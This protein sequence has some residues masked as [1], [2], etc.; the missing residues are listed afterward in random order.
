MMDSLRDAAKSWVAKLLIGLLAVSFGVWGIADVF[1][2]YNQG[3]L[4][5]VG[6]VD[7]TP[8]AYNIA[9][10]RYLQNMQRQTGQT[11]TPDEARKFGID[12]A[13]LDNLIQT[14]AIDD[15]ARGLKLA[16]S[17]AL[18]AKDTASNP[19]FQDSSGKF[20]PAEFRRR[21][22]QNGL[23]EAMFL[24]SE[25]EGRLREAVTG[26]VDGGFTVPKT[27]VEALYRH[28]NEQRDVRYFTVTTADSEVAIP[29]EAEIKK[30]YDTNPPSFTAPEY[31]SIAIMKVEPADITAKVS[32]TE[33]ELKQ[34]Y[35]KY[36]ADYA[37]PERRTILQL[38]FPTLDDANKAKG[39]LAAGA[40]FIA[41]AKERGFTEA[42]VTFADKSRADFIDQ[43]IAD[44]AFKLTEG[45]LS[46]P[47]KGGLSTAL[48]KVVKIVPGHQ[49]T[50]DEVR[51]KLT[52]R[53]K[54]ER[55]SEEIDSLY[56]A[57]EDARGA[58]TKFE[59]I[60]E[61]SGIPFQL[62]TGIDANGKDKDGKDIPL[63]HKAEVL[64]AAFASDVGVD[65]DAVSL[66]HGYVWYDV[67]EV[68]P[69]AVKPFEQVKD[70]AKAQAIAAKVRERA[71]SKA[72]ALVASARSGASLEDLARDA[73]SEIKTA[74]GLKRNESGDSFDPQAVAAIFAVPENGFASA[75]DADGRTAKV[76][77]SQAVLMA[78][79]DAASPDAK[80][81]A[82]KMQSAAAT[83]LLTAYLGDLQQAAGVKVNDTLWRQL[84]GT[85]T[86]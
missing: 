59:D 58:S 66:E 43:A 41:I 12:R 6:G 68:V 57:V 7:V 15:Q 64:K 25:R 38:S 27:L 79:F 63:P 51:D 70:Q 80:A 22:D 20:D 36:Q 42:D 4:A 2:G 14:A 37:T 3:S 10:N 69:S 39:Q 16:V 62:V 21:L 24:E 60:A 54:L 67:R 46:E 13:V 78:P 5:S 8:A 32:I 53:L 72:E 65:N 33:D 55:A 81:I 74:Q 17:D 40:D 75:I 28:E 50:L 86:Q 30:E 1:R 85:A 47:V 77:Q 26:S 73:K 61:K 83:D 29:T 82:G 18:I 9:F 35:E 44:A 31:R 49:S 23:N 71:A 84:S 34:G 56:G 19:A 45:A 48:I 52:E 76:M 11:M